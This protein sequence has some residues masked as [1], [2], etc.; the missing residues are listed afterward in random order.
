MTALES[1]RT[2]IK[3]NLP[4]KMPMPDRKLCVRQGRDRMNWELM[5]KGEAAL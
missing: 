1:P 2:G 4:M 3:P 5:F